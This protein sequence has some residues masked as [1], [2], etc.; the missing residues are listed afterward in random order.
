MASPQAA[1]TVS[2]AVKMN[3]NAVGKPKDASAG[4]TEPN[5]K[6]KKAPPS[7]ARAVAASKRSIPSD[8]SNNSKKNN[9]KNNGI[10][11]DKIITKLGPYDVL[12]GR[13]VTE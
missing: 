3:T 5:N 9:T 7:N 10:N 8:D 6:A 12:L 11:A 13:Y 2:N 4:E 1:A